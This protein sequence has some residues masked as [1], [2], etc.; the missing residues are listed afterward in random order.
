MPRGEIQRLMRTGQV[1]VNGGRAK[2]DRRLALGD[3]VRI[4]PLTEADQKPRERGAAPPA[5][6]VKRLAER[7]IY[8]DGWMLVLDKPVGVPVHGGSGHEWGVVDAMRVYLDELGVVASPEL[9]H[10]L[11]KET[12]GCLVFG[13]TPKAVREL[14]RAFRDGEVEKQYL[15]LVQ[16]APKPQGRIARNLA[17]GQVRGGERM[18]AASD[19]EGQEAATRYAMHERFSFCALME[20]TLETGRTHQIRVHFQD[21]GHPVAGDGK[22]GDKSFN[23]QMKSVGLK[24]MFLHAWRLRLK[25]PHEGR[26]M[27]FTA[28][29]DDGLQSVLTALRDSAP[30]SSRPRQTQPAQRVQGKGAQPRSERRGGAPSARRRGGK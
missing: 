5:A 14:T 12:S 6:L 2:G 30:K 7:I 26:W 27:E 18:V 13:L 23:Q 15:T 1:R 17:K 11:D 20:A 22:Y 28:P 29:L 25:H 9:C 24:R 4:P 21:L 19:G 16:G 8:R 3:Q 10:R